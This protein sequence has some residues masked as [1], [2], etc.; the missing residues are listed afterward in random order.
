MDNSHAPTC[1]LA[2]AKLPHTCMSLPCSYVRMYIPAAQRNG[3]FRRSNHWHMANQPSTWEGRGSTLNS[4]N[5][6]TKRLPRQSSNA[7]HDQNFQPT[8]EITH[9]AFLESAKLTL[10]D[11]N[12][13]RGLSRYVL[14]KNKN[15]TLSVE[16]G[17]G[18]LL[19]YLTARSAE[20]V[21]QGSLRP[22]YEANK[23]LQ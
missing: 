23:S 2:A 15:T 19:V 3:F 5:K 6:I 13:V 1:R 7:D 11:K 21:Y 22:R 14:E 18:E 10:C 12:K 20:I 16:P 9:I 4:Y 8:T 17:G